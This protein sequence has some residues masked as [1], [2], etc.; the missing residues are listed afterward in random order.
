[1]GSGSLI[2]LSAVNNLPRVL[3]QKNACFLTCRQTRPLD[4]CKC[5]HKFLQCV[6]THSSMLSARAR[7]NSAACWSPDMS[8]WPGFCNSTQGGSG[9]MPRKSSKWGLVCFS[10]D[11]STEDLFAFCIISLCV[12]CILTVKIDSPINP[13]YCFCHMRTNVC[14]NLVVGVRVCMCVCARID[15]YLR[16]VGLW[17]IS[18][19]LVWSPTMSGISSVHNNGSSLSEEFTPNALLLNCITVFIRQPYWIYFAVVNLPSFYCHSIDT[20]VNGFIVVFFRSFFFHSMANRQ[21]LSQT[22]S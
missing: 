1:M 3:L 21:V 16:T 2:S 12:E 19:L 17:I 5:I 20:N 13:S 4:T 6:S 9:G 7:R 14:Q 10:P 22:M 18:Q 15:A 8:A 11:T